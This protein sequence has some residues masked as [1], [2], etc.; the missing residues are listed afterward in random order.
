MRT[1]ANSRMDGV[2][3]VWKCG[4]G[5]RGEWGCKVL[6]FI[7]HTLKQWTKL[8]ISGAAKAKKIHQSQA[9]YSVGRGRRWDW[10]CFT[11]ACGVGKVKGSSPIR[12]RWLPGSREGQSGRCLFLAEI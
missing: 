2:S 8:K 4:K 12:S 5:K 7:A 3:K 6:T 11:F 10:W 1:R 9:T